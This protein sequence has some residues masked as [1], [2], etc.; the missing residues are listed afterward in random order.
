MLPKA[1]LTSHSKMS[2]AR[3]VIM[4]TPLWLSGS[5]GSVFYS[6]SVYCCHHF[7]ISSA[8]VR[9]IP[10]LSF[11]VP[12]FAR[13]VPLVSLI[14]LKRSW[15]FP[16]LLFSSISLYWSLRKAFLSLLAILWNSAF[17]W[18]YLS[19][20]PLLFAFFFSQLFIR[21]P[22][23]TILPFCISFSW[24]WSW[25]PPPCSIRIDRAEVFIFYTSFPLSHLWGLWMH[26]VKIQNLTESIQKCLMND[27][28]IINKS[29]PKWPPLLTMLCC[30]TELRYCLCF[31][32][33]SHT[34]KIEKVFSLPQ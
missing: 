15:V 6:S 1:H 30:S 33:F 5:L 24:G 21:A 26:V 12:I 18:E 29:Y 11:S 20:S 34:S 3:W 14:F 19:F 17:K 27:E 22:Q 9:S 4:S 23:A 10:F 25:S 2:G 7:L 28:Y 31:S 32:C 16:V 8:S 13:N